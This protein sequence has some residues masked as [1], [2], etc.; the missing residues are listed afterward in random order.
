[1]DDVRK[2]LAVVHRLADLGNT[3]VIIEHNLEV[4][5]TADWVIDLGPEAGAE[6]GRV[7]A[8]GPPEAIVKAKGSLTGAILKDILAAGPHEPRPKF[9]PKAA[10]RKVIDAAKSAPPDEFGANVKP[11]WEVDGRRW[12]TRDRVARS[13]RP[14]RWDGRILERVVDRIHELGQFPET[15]WSQRTIVRIDAP[16]EEPSPFF[17]AQTG[18]EWVV[19]LRFFVPANTFKPSALETQLGL[20]PF[21][22]GPTPVLSDAPR[23]MVTA[24]RG[25]MQEIAITCHSAEDL[26]TSGFDAFLAR[27]VAAAPG[28][29][30]S[31][32]PRPASS[33]AGSSRE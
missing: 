5:K 16:G 30:G 3:V 21:D 7:V 6:G 20:T 8:E 29:P 15:D 22:A 18:H 19:T 23:L 26:M 33:L 9:D 1:M 13:G 32:R 4:I 24:G 25:R 27:A 17:Q 12:H 14:A 11:P 31:V 10:A 2:L 28:R